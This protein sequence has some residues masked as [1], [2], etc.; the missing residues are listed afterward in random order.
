MSSANKP[1]KMAYITC[2]CFYITTLIVFIGYYEYKEIFDNNKI[3][4]LIWAGFI[5]FTIMIT[6]AI[7][8][9]SVIFTK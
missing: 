4:W 3:S 1:G 2:I 5:I 9:P 8:G 7:L 6:I